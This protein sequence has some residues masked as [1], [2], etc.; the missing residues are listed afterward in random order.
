MVE[1]SKT[2]ELNPKKT[3]LLIIDMQN[4]FCHEKGFMARRELDIS[5]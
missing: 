4:D 3:A 2:A 1:E 5:A